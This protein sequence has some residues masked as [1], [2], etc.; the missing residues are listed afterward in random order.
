M[1]K[2]LTDQLRTAIDDSGLT[3]YEIAKR[4]GIDESALAKFYNGHRGLS[5]EGLNA[6][7][8]CLGLSIVSR[9]KPAKKG[10]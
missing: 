8:E 9:R 5:M 10:K 4:T 1:P 6:L 2:Q 7:G 3:R